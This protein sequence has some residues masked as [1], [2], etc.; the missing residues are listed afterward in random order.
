MLPLHLA[1]Q[2]TFRLDVIGG[3]RNLDWSLAA[4]PRV[5]DG[6][7]YPSRSPLVDAVAASGASCLQPR[8]RLCLRLVS[9]TFPS[10]LCK[11]RRFAPECRVNSGNSVYIT[12]RATLTSERQGP[13]VWM[14]KP[15]SPYARRVISKTYGLASSLVVWNRTSRVNGRTVASGPRSAQQ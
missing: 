4:G 7:S 1:A 3:H 13:G 2:P 10:T 9:P 11:C 14:R 15:S 6:S 5:F 8:R 12:S